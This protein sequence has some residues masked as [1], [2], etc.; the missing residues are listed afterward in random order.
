LVTREQALGILSLIG[1]A[2]ITLSAALA[3]YWSMTEIE[4]LKTELRAK[5]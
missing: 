2:A 1:A 5:K 4:Q 3:L